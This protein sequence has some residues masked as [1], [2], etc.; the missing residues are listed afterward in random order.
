MY[1]SR[2]RMRPNMDTTQ[3]AELLK[4]RKG[5]GLHRLFWGLFSEGEI[6]KKQR[7][8]LFREEIEGEQLKQPGKRSAA[9]I[10][11]VLSKTKPTTDSPLFEVQTKEYQPKLSKGDHLSFKLRVNAVITRNSKRHDIVMDAQQR[12]LKAQLALLGL[13]PQGAKRELKNQLLDHA[14][15]HMLSRWKEIIEQGVFSQKTEQSLGRTECLDWVLKT[16]VEE[17]VQQWWQRKGDRFGFDIACG[18]QGQPVLESVAY[19]KHH[20][21]E[22]GAKAGFSSLDLSGEIVVKEVGDLEKLLFEGIGPA[23]AFGCG[24]MMVRRI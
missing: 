7:D 3:L 24:L 22:K 5:Y 23:K 4:D 6:N 2:V 12:W 14:D 1:L 17:A 20:L 21:P 9:P 15:D 19:Q 10:Y 16:V 13:E 8:F 11:Y 18:P